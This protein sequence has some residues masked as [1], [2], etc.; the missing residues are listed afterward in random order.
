MISNNLDLM[1]FSSHKMSYLC[2]NAQKY[3]TKIKF[4]GIKFIKIDRIWNRSFQKRIIMEMRLSRVMW[5]EK[6][7]IAETR[8]YWLK[9]AVKFSNL[10]LGCDVWRSAELKKCVKKVK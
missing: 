4:H 3:K 10:R 1:R 2:V 9:Q 7:I 6:T 5:L 8:R